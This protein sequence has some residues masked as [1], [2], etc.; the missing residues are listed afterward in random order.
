MEGILELINMILQRAGLRQ[1]KQYARGVVRVTMNL[2]SRPISALLL[3]LLA[4]SMVSAVSFA[5]G[6]GSS[7]IGKLATSG[8]VSIDGTSAPTGTVVFSGDRIATQ[9]F[10]AL[11][12]FLKGSSVVLTQGT[13]AS[14]SRSGKALM[15]IAE[16]GVLGF[17]F[18]AGEDVSI[19]AGTC[20]FTASARD[21]AITGELALSSR[22]EAEM[23]V[24][25]GNFSVSN[26]ATGVR[27]EVSP[28]SGEV[29]AQLWFG[30]GN[31]AKGRN[32][33][34]DP[35]KK[36]EADELKGMILE[37]SGEQHK[38]RSNTAT[39]ITIEG[40]WALATGAYDYGIEKGGVS[41]GA[42]VAIAAAVGGGGA[43]G[44]WVA[45]KSKK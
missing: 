9:E 30:I 12:S 7:P 1:S 39:T 16:K 10:P 32:T 29:P 45:T 23:S 34:S 44:I 13:T 19:Q 20:K 3:S 5:E 22:G 2:L 14:F 11:I 21:Q 18:L 17:N 35:S 25:S 8:R 24:S 26:T 31:L 41:T 40:V 4:I 37:V 28:S 27:S 15:I 6:S 42:K 36:W 43:V 38:I 33:L